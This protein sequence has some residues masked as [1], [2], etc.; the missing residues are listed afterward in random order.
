MWTALSVGILTLIICVAVQTMASGLVL[1][2][3]EWMARRGW[4]ENGFWPGV[5]ILEVTSLALFASFLIQIT[6]WSWVLGLVYEFKGGYQEAFYHSANN[7]TTLSYGE[8]VL[9]K[10]W[11]LLGPIEAA[12]GIVM[13]G[14]AAAVMFAVMHKITEATAKRRN[15]FKQ[16]LDT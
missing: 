9:S 2:T 1:W 13:A 3:V 8:E 4:H 16:P 14:L 15:Q 12:N 6:I 10:D 5:L 11:R 7:Y